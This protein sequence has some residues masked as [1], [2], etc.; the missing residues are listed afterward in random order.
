LSPLTNTTVCSPSRFDVLL[1][2]GERVA[3]V[4]PVKSANTGQDALNGLS[5]CFHEQNP[6]RCGSCKGKLLLHCLYA[7]IITRAALAFLHLV[8]AP[9]LET[10]WARSG[11]Q[12][13]RG[14]ETRLRKGATQQPQMVEWCSWLSRQSNTLKVSSSSLDLIITLVFCSAVR[15]RVF[16]F[17]GGSLFFVFGI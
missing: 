9:S 1:V 14:S 17:G 4:M 11:H 10:M 3:R 13:S 2:L 12:R 8:L 7:C 15:A 6:K 5:H 16:C